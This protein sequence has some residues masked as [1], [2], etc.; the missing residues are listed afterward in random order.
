MFV[1]NASPPAATAEPVIEND[2]WF[3]PMDPAA[4]RGACLLD[5][6]VTAA[7]LRPALVEA[8]LTINRELQ[9][10]ASHQ[11]AQGHASLADVP[12][13][14]IA[15]DSARLLHYRRAVH[16]CLQADLAEAYRIQSFMPGGTGNGKQDGVQEALAVRQDEH[17]RNQRWAIADIVGRPRATVELI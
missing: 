13:P 1:A 7:R 9:D 14:R 4:V 5:G 6:T 3:P 17:R 12:G 2:G 10:W 11:R 15:G 16:A 8:M